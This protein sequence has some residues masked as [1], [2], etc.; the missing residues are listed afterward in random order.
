MKILILATKYPNNTGDYSLMYIHTRAKYYLKS[1][2]Q[3]TVINFSAQ[4]GYNIDG[5]DVITL[6]SYKVSNHHYDIVLSHAPNLRNHFKFLK[7]YFHRFK[8]VIYFF[9]GHEILKYNKHYPKAYPFV[10]DTHSKIVRDIYDEFKLIV[11][12]CFFMKTRSISHFVFVSDFLYSLFSKYIKLDIESQGRKHIINNSISETFEINKYD[13]SVEKNFDYVTVR[14]NIDSSTYAIDLLL[15]LVNKH[16]N[17]S[18]LLIGKGDFFQYNDIP[19]N[20]TFINRTFNHEEL[21]KYLNQSRVALMLTRHDTQG[22]MS[23]EIASFGMPLITSKLKV[24]EEIFSSFSNVYLIDNN[25]VGCA[26]L[27]EIS[28]KLNYSRENNQTYCACNTID[29]EIELFK[30]ILMYE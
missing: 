1:G 18:F 15:E 10:K 30:S 22:V 19:S 14:S 23:C 25:T 6:E 7:R 12:R 9:H 24:T 11:W 5:I 17:K 29:K 4:E 3:V 28:R 8:A 27:N 21:I 26:D 20:L 13:K 2:A 16:H